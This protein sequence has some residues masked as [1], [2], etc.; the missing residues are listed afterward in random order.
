MRKVGPLSK[1][2]KTL[3]A[4]EKYAEG[5]LRPSSRNREGSAERFVKGFRQSVGRV[6]GYREESRLREE[7]KERKDRGENYARMRLKCSR[8]PELRSQSRVRRNVILKMEVAVRNRKGQIA[9]HEGEDVQE[10]VHK[11]AQAFQMKDDME[12][13][14]L[15]QI[16][17][18]LRGERSI[19]KENRV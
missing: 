6:K 19:R 16:E 4:S 14:L 10:A 9:L 5:A 18:K 3:T 12:L 15:R 17:E 11:F 8:E 7:R 2:E 13:V 1:E